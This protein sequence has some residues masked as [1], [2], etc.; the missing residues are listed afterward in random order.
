MAKW[1]Y[2]A[3]ALGWTLSMIYECLQ[4]GTGTALYFSLGIVGVTAFVIL[5]VWNVNR[6][7]EQKPV[8][9]MLYFMGAAV[10]AAFFYMALGKAAAAGTYVR[11]MPFYFVMFAY[12]MGAGLYMWW[13]ALREKK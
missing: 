7:G 6:G 1:I 2:A 12:F 11:F 9:R 4:T 13:K 8:P 5:F 10:S 3:L